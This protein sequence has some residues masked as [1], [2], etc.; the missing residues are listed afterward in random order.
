MGINQ[1]FFPNDGQEYLFFQF[2][3][4]NIFVDLVFEIFWSPKNFGGH[5]T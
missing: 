1:K 4:Q 2:N 3:N 5:S